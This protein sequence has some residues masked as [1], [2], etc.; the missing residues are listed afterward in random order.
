MKKKISKFSD[1]VLLL[2]QDCTSSQV[3]L[4]DNVV[5]ASLDLKV[6]YVPTVRV[7][8]DQHFDAP[9]YWS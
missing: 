4:C 8:P 5:S 2:L 1:Q 3:Y 6:I 9:L 7:N